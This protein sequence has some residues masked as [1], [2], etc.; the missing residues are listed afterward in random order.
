[1]ETVIVDGKIGVR[2]GQ[3]TTLP[4]GRKVKVIRVNVAGADGIPDKM[5]V[6]VLDQ[7]S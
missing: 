2:P 7:K 1:M 4:D 5:E 3:Q 6:Q